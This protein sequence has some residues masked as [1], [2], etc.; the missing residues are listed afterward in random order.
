MERGRG[1][2]SPSQ[3]ST[4]QPGGLTWRELLAGMALE[5]PGC[6][7]ASIAIYNPDRDRHGVGADRVVEFATRLVAGASRVGTAR[8]TRL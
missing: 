3:P 2:P 1:A 4:I 6:A 7:G 5:A 8:V